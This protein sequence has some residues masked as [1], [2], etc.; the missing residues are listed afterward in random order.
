MEEQTLLV[1]LDDYLKSGLHI[2][3]KFRT[4]FMSKF[5]YK[6]R[7]DG[8]SILDV[9][10]IDK[11]LSI[12]SNLISKY[13]E[14]DIIVICRR[15]NGFKPVKKF[16][17]LTGIECIT[18]RYRPGR[19]TNVELEDF[20]EKK[21]LIVCDPIPDKNAVKDASNLGIPVIGL[22]DTNNECKNIDLVVACN[23]KGKKSLGLVFF[24]LA[25]EFLLRKNLIKTKEEFKYALEDF[26]E[27]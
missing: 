3:N 21:L 18:G 24:I 15:E 23:N 25:R 7:P 26:A 5:I 6:I 27:Q 22:C 10:S 17:E 2:G 8:L 19:L 20:T 11:R 14:K 4:K 13:N 9:E 16:S 1:Q 12:A